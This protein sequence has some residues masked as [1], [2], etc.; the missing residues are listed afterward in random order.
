MARPWTTDGGSAL[1]LTLLV[2][3]AI[4]LVATVF[5]MTAQTESHIAVNETHAVQARYAAEAGARAVLGW[6]EQPETA[7]GFP[8]VDAVVRD[9]RIVDEADPYGAAP[10]P[11]GPQYKEGVD[12]DAD[13]REDLFEAPHRGASVHALLGTED[14]PDL[15]IQDEVALGR[16]SRVLFDDVAGGESGVRTRIR[17]VDIYAPP[18]LPVGPGWVRHGVGTAKVSAAIERVTASGSEILAERT[19]R[20]TLNQVPYVPSRLE[21]VHACGAAELIGPVGVRWGALTATGTLSM[22]TGPAVPASLP[23]GVPGPD[24]GDRLW[25]DD[26]AWVA[27]FDA[28]LHPLERLD[29][30][31][32]RLA[33]G[34]AIPAAPSPQAMPWAGPPPPPPGTAPPWP[35]C[36]HSNVLQHQP[37]VTCPEY[38]YELWKRLARSGSR[39]AHYYAWHPADGFRE[40]G[41]A[42]G[43]SFTRI[44][45]ERAGDPGLYFF[46]TADGRRPI[47][48]DGDG[49]YDNLTPPIRL[50]GRW[51]ARGLV[52]VNAEKLVVSGLVDT[53]E[54]TVQAP[55]EPFVGGPDAWVNLVY[56]DALDAPFRP[57]GPGAWDARGPKVAVAAA[58]RGVLVTQGAFEAN[59][60][61]T[62]L[63]AVI[64]RSVVLDGSVGRA[65][66]FYRDPSLDEA[67]PPRGWGLPRFVVSRSSVD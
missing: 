67:W 39:G 22:P 8:R 65:T 10:R 35:C 48:R 9:R 53:I 42:P 59:H 19:V 20:V 62:F 12:L 26:P 16:L 3:V 34:G 38:D 55:G 28:S 41:A 60:G 44:L 51:S 54:E 66:R 25:T 29:D 2:T 32:V 30:P 50:E 37:W 18:Y 31:W 61:G 46:D 23:R 58:F 14:A 49:A 11:G 13:G 57:A 7:P 17:R 47:D 24:G 5:L 33:A 15:R 43:E 63:G 6:F 27:A 21:A 36:D 40:D 1:L 64:A 4:V 56:P 52:F 45:A